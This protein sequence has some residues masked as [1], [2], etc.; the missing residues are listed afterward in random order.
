MFIKDLYLKFLTKK[1]DKYS[2]KLQS[3]LESKDFTLITSNCCGGIIYHRLGHKF[4]SPTINLW[5]TDEDY[6]TFIYNLKEFV[7]KGELIEQDQTEFNYPVAK[8]KAPCGEITVYF[9][10]YKTFEEANEKWIERCSRINWNKLVFIWEIK[11]DTKQSVIDK[12]NSFNAKNKL[13]Y[14]MK[15]DCDSPYLVKINCKK[16]YFHGYAFQHKT[17][18]ASKRWLDDVDYVS[19]I[20]GT[21]ENN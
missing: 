11:P 18:F 16:D 19:L 14:S 1:R 8:L 3:R 20:N 21:K 15:I 5:F 2:K 7:E 13:I 10:H 9:M 17:K 6:V 4:L 12:F